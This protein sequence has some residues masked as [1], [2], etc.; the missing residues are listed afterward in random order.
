MFRCF[1]GRPRFLSPPTLFFVLFA[2]L[3]V[4]FYGFAELKDHAANVNA[5]Y[6]MKR[7]ALSNNVDK[8]RLA[9]AVLLPPWIDEWSLSVLDPFLNVFGFAFLIK[10]IHA[11]KHGVLFWVVG[12]GVDVSC[13]EN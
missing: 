5:I 8:G 13:E 11:S 3:L 12:G 6:C 4:L 7:P 2:T 1:L 10:R 9:K